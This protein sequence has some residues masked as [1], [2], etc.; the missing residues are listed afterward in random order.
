MNR[1]S[2]NFLV[3]PRTINQERLQT[4]VTLHHLMEFSQFQIHIGELNQYLFE[5][6]LNL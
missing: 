6:D 5:L 4:E 2:Q 1:F 3:C